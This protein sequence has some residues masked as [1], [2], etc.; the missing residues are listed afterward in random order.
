MSR[1]I[2]TPFGKKTWGFHAGT[3]IFGPLFSFFQLKVMAGMATT[4]IL[5]IGI[6]RTAAAEDQRKGKFLLCHFAGEVNTLILQA[7]MGKD[8]SLRGE[9]RLLAW[10]SGIG[11]HDSLNFGRFLTGQSPDNRWFFQSAVTDVTADTL[12]GLLIIV[13]KTIP[14]DLRV[15]VAIDTVQLVFTEGKEGHG[16]VVIL[17]ATFFT[18]ESIQIL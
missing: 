1:K 2:I 14:H 6:L 4:R 9:H 3:S 15:C 5:D 18:M 12:L 11:S 13:K 16:I 8:L 10:I 17:Y 7:N